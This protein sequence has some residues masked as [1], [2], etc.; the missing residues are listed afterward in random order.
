MSIRLTKAPRTDKAA[1]KTGLAAHGAIAAV[2]AT[3][4]LLGGFGAFA[5]WQDTGEIGAEG[6]MATGRLAIESVES[7]G[8]T[9]VGD[10]DGNHDGVFTGDV[11]DPVE[12]FRVSP[13]DVLQWSGRAAF[14]AEG[15]DLRAQFGAAIDPVVH[16]DL[17]DYVTVTVQVGKDDAEGPIVVIGD[18][19]GDPQ[20][21]DVTVRVAFSR[22][23]GRNEAHGQAI[24]AVSLDELTLTLTQV[25]GQQLATD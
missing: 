19:T 17:R 6:T 18:A 15:S 9:L 5:L 3:A 2:T 1:G 16:R 8:W 10:E 14:V 24:D 20:S 11:I 21:V 22:D 7:H 12:D 13:G 23:F 4:V 25:A